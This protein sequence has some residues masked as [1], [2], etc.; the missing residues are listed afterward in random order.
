MSNLLITLQ[1]LVFL[2]KFFISLI[3]KK[4]ESV[5]TYYYD[6]VFGYAAEF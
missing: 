2:I 1:V 5:P 6:E 3:S 4:I